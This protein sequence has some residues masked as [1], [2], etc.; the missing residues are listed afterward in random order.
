MKQFNHFAGNKRK[1]ILF[2]V[3]FPLLLAA[4]ILLPGNRPGVDP[5]A[6][7]D[8]KADTSL[9]DVL[10]RGVLR[11]T[12]NY[13]STNYFIYRG[14]PMGFHLELLRLFALDLGVELEVMV[15]NE[16]SEQLSC[17]LEEG[18]CDLLA[19]DLTVTRSRQEHL[20]F[21]EPHSRTRQMLVQRNHTGGAAA[22]PV[23]SQLD[24][25]GKT[26]HVQKNSAFAGRLYSLMEEIGS[27]IHIVEVEETV[28][29]LIEKVARGE[30]DFTVSDE[31]LARLHRNYF[32]N[33]DVSLPLSFEQNLS[34]AVRPGSDSLAAAVNRWMV[35]FRETAQYAAI[36]SKY[37]N[38]SRSVFLAKSPL[39]SLG[40]GMVSNYDSYFKEY[41]RIV[42][43]DWRLIASLAYQESRFDPGAVSWAGAFGLMQLM[44][45]TA[46]SLD[47]GPESSVPQH[48]RAG[49]TYLQWIDGVLAEHIQDEEERVR[50]VLASYNMGIGHVMDARRLAEKYG[51][52][53]NVW[54]NNVDYFV[55]NKSQPKY[56]NDP[57][58]KFG[59]ARGAEPYNYV[60]EILERY[61]HYLN[62]LEG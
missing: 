37:Y 50:F 41:S 57:V 62:A 21:T 45:G 9:S 16:I 52:D 8:H 4:G 38:N 7:K 51:R 31:H 14:E 36:Y 61:A 17:L 58:V 10:E 33:L 53:P 12:T 26:I 11:A 2:F 56:Y 49:V 34:W 19:L 40:G 24:L 47:V 60:N 30:I 1:K 5:Y 13:N 15:S 18:S 35:S 32:R 59:Y 48:I 3:V 28:E 39:H 54:K 44:P 46:E 43:W 55:L 27:G 25:A 20:L 23:R 29:Q 6:A 42:G 22:G